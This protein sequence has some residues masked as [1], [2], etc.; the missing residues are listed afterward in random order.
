MNHPW[1]AL[2]LP[3]CHNDEELATDQS[4]IFMW[5]FRPSSRGTKVRRM[6]SQRMSYSHHRSC[7]SNT[8]M[9]V[10]ILALPKVNTIKRFLPLKHH[11]SWITGANAI[12][13]GCQLPR[14]AC[15]LNGPR[16]KP[17]RQQLATLLRLL[18]LLPSQPNRPW[19]QKSCESNILRTLDRNSLIDH[20]HGSLFQ[21]GMT[22]RIVTI[23]H[24]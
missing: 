10:T 14:R 7:Y 17:F 4:L 9:L 21:E 23:A 12:H 2:V 8:R 18:Q 5:K 1:I 16:V 15:F 20:F 3:R 24:N 13:D 11:E 19:T 22:L 6:I